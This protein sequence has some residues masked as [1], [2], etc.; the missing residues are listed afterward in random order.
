M[1]GTWRSVNLGGLSKGDNHYLKEGP[2]E[3]SSM[4]SVL[5][6]LLL[7]ASPVLQQLAGKCT[8]QVWHPNLEG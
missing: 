5:G 6:Y 3:D 7:P 1:G 2:Y 4:T 8:V